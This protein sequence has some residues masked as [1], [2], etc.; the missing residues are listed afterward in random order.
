MSKPVGFNDSATNH[1]TS[2]TP[3][4]DLAGWNHSVQHIVKI[5]R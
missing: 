4:Y 5:E 1:F 2:I 3:R